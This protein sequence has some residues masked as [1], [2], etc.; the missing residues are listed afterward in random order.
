MGHQI[1]KQPN[2]KFAL[3]ST[4]TDDFLLEDVTPSEI[5]DY[6]IKCHSRFVI[7]HTINIVQKLDKGEKPYYQFTLTWEECQRRMLEKNEGE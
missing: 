1:I 4:V 6:E 3:W 5:A 7:D 2:G